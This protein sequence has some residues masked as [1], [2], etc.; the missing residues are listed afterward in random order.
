MNPTKIVYIDDNLSDTDPLII[1]LGNEFG[2]SNVTLKRKSSE[3]LAYV[4]DN[5]GGKLIVLL[6]LDLGPGEPHG[7]EVFEKIREK[8]S[9]VY[10]II[11]TAKQL[12]TIDGNELIKFIN[13][14]A[15][16]IINNT[17]DIDKIINLVYRA[18][19]QL[20]VR[21]DCVL[22]EWILNRPEKERKSIY[23]STRSGKEYTLEDIVTEIRRQTSL[24]KNLE[25]GILQ[26]AIELLTT[27]KEQIN[28]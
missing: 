2:Q 22:E 28:D 21:I 26:L 16:A 13:N 10:I 18:S 3:G 25:K 20:D 15:L 11:I 23:L 5:I 9:L 17:E 4:L 7:I 12:N 27:K 14:D 24:G 19:H 6:D 1:E 8:T